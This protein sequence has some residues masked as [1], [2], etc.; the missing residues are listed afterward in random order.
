MNTTAT[1]EIE[2]GQAVDVFIRFGGIRDLAIFRGDIRDLSRKQE[3]EAGIPVARGSGNSYFGGLGCEI[4][5]GNG[6]G[7]GIS[8]PA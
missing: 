4:G 3:R 7:Y 2:P 1:A 6:A 5:K 8:I